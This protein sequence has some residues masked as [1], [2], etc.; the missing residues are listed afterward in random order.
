M[1]NNAPNLMKAWQLVDFGQPLKLRYVA[2]PTAHPGQVVVRILA[3]GLCH[4]DVG[5]LSDEKWLAGL[6]NLPLTLGHEVS[7]VISSSRT[8]GKEFLC[9]GSRGDISYWKDPTWPRS[10]RGIFAQVR[11]IFRGFGQAS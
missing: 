11:G 6:G 4:T 9:W 1:L 8:R 5:I 10:G 7:G 2:E 3:A